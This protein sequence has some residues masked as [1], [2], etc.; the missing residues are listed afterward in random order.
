MTHLAPRPWVP[1]AAEAHVQ[2]LAR[3]AAALDSAAL[4]AR[5]EALIQQ[6]Q[7]IHEQECFNLNPATNVMN[8]RAEAALAR[9]LGSRPSLGYPG[10]KYE[11]GLQA[12]EEI[13][14][15]A[16]E[17]AAEVFGATHAEIRVA[18]GALANL[19]GFMALA[20]PGDAIIAPPPSIGGHV[21]HHADGCAGLYGL[22]THPAPVDADGYTVD[23]KALR[24]LALK[25]RPKIITVGGSLNLFPHPVPQIRAIADEVGAKVLFDAAHQC[26]IIAGGVWANPLA[27]GAHLMTMSTYKSLGGPAGGLIVTNDAAIAE[28]LDRIAFPGLT[29]NF[30]AAKSAALAISLLDWREHGRAYAQAMADTARAFAEALAAAGLPVFAA[31]KGFT[32]SHQFAVEAAGF[33]GGQAASKTLEKAGFLACGIG[34]P[35]APVEGDLNGLRIGT[36]ELVR[37]GVTPADIP[38]IAALV[39]EA[40]RSNDPAAVAPRTRALRARFDRLHYVR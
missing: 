25:V 28:R 35:I 40:L 1:A 8:P 21:T 12:I 5:I 15:I 31:E 37:W 2:T 30:D 17:L 36:P 27:Q 39:A 6:N 3:A 11:M 19:Y 23:L 32:T 33:G 14:V 7:R 34:L 18:S 26:G 38:E 29:A 13:E 22:I 16:A 20:R 24:D 4:D 9:G 10:D